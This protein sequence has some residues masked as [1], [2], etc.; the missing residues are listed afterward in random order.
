VENNAALIAVDDADLG[1][2]L[3]QILR[4]L[5]TAQ[6]ASELMGVNCD[7]QE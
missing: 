4:D 3:P 7:V 1:V 5:M 2:G 6:P